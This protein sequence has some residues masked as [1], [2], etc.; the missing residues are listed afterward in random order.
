VL[1]RDYLTIPADQIKDIAPVM[2]M[3]GGRIVYEAKP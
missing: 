1:D 2:T 3:I